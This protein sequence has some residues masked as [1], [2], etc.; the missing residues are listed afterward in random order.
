MERQVI[1]ITSL[2]ELGFTSTI[3]I[4]QNEKPHFRLLKTGFID[5]LKAL[6]ISGAPFIFRDKYS[7]F[8]LFT[9]LYSSLFLKAAGCGITS[10]NSYL[11]QSKTIRRTSRKS[12]PPRPSCRTMCVFYLRKAEESD[13][14]SNTLAVR[15]PPLWRT[16]EPS[17]P[18]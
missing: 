10:E 2:F 12:C 5:N 14:N 18:L 7:V 3:F 6:R 13:R 4:F 17:R 1:H 16:F 15:C 8:R 9:A 11:G